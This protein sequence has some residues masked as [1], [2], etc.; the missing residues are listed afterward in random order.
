L[1]K[2][3]QE[4]PWTLETLTKTYAQLSHT[5][6]QGLEQCLGDIQHAH[7]VACARRTALK[8]PQHEQPVAWTEERAQAVTACEVQMMRLETL[9][10]QVL[11]RLKT[12]RP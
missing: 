2:T 8:Q 12:D 10:R 7:R 11:A 3:G 9:R 1:E 6:R 4:L 5:Y